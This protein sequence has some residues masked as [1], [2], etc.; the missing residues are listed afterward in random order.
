LSQPIPSKDPLANP[1]PWNAIAVGYDEEF[2]DRLPEL[3][4]EAVAILA[5]TASDRVLDVGTGPGA[6]AMRLAPKVARV[7]AIDFADQ[8]IARLVAR[9]D[10]AGATNVEP[11]VMDGHALE[12]DDGSFD[13]VV[14]MFGWFLFD[15]RARALGEMHR[16][17]APGGRLL[18][19]SWATIEQNTVLG[20]GLVAMRAALP[21]LPRR[22]G[23]M[24]TQLP[25]VV[26]GELRS[27][28]FRDVETKIVTVPAVFSS[29]DE[30]FRTLERASAPFVLLRKRLGDEAFAAACERAKAALHERFHEAP[31]LQAQAIYACGTR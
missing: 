26:A 17:L 3:L 23:P 9:R 8:M 29:V 6:I 13:A 14:S 25:E 18:V 10:A 1:E 5:P 22:A 12:F 21:D 15:D 7:A 30:Y 19:S 31:E 11:A 28:G 2:S 24:P 16:V 4:D 27:A 20:A